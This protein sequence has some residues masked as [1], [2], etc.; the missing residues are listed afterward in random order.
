MTTRDL[1]KNPHVKVR[2]Q[3][4]GYTKPR[5]QGAAVC[6]PIDP[7]LPLRI[8]LP[9]RIY[10]ELNMRGGVPWARVRRFKHHKNAVR[11][12]M[13]R[14]VAQAWLSA[15]SGATCLSVRLVRIGKRYLDDDGVPSGFKSV[16]DAIAA[17]IGVDDGNRDFWRWSY[18]QRIE[19]RYGIE[20]EI[21]R[22]AL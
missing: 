12:A 20:I 16:R 13:A 9:L 11:D 17:V 5:E 2:G 18:D 8:E 19:K 4:S 15:H 6:V 21:Q 10:S 22:I 14:P 1:L 3:Q 7:T